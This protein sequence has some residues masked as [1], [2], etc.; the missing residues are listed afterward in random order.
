M[1]GQ[2]AQIT[3]TSKTGI[4]IVQITR[5][6][7]TGIP[8][9]YPLKLVEKIEYQMFL[10]SDTLI[11]QQIVPSSVDRKFQMQLSFLILDFKYVVFFVSCKPVTVSQYWYSLERFSPNYSL[12]LSAHDTSPCFIFLAS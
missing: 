10:F 5:T 4:L 3:K 9:Q 12:I 2:S 6:G 8:I 7:I 1:F 11:S